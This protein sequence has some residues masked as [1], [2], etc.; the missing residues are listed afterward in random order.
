M[1]KKLQNREEL[2]AQMRAEEEDEIG[3]ADKPKQSTDDYLEVNDFLTQI[4]KN[5]LNEI[6]M[7]SVVLKNFHKNQELQL[8]NR[9]HE[10][11]RKSIEELLSD[12]KKN[13]HRKRNMSSKSGILSEIDILTETDSED[14]TSNEHTL[15]KTD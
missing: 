11:N 3:G 15:G 6:K 8:I 5:Q 10:I 13:A 4:Q 9:E 12:K 2:E 7:S 14:E 1:L